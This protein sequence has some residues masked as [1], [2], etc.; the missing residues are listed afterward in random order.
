MKLE[1]NEG[2]Q[3]IDGLKIDFWD[4]NVV[5]G[6]RRGPEIFARQGYGVVVE[7]LQI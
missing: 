3:P 7:V 4:F 6:R 1:L 2:N 5:H